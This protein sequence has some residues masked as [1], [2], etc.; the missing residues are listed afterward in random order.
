M[1]RLHERGPA[2]IEANLTPMIDITFLLVV[3]FVVVSTISEVES[4]E[5]QLPKPQPTASAP[6][7]EQSRSVLNVLPD[8][9]GEA[10]GYRLNTVEY[11][12]GKTGIDALQTAL[13]PLLRNNPEL[14]INLRADRRTS[15]RHIA[16]LLNVITEANTRAGTGTP[17]RVNLV[18]VTRREETE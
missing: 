9:D 18:V 16:P 17:A 7:P 3:F 12:L 2:Q 11:P 10:I 13:V 15:Q 5:M 14:R 8:E 1:T 6:P 4:V